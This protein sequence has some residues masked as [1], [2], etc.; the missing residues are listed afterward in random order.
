MGEGLPE[1]RERE[2]RERGILFSDEMV[3]RILSG[4]K[5]R[6]R[7]YAR[8][9]EDPNAPE[10]IA[11]RLANGLYS[12]PPDGC[13]VWTRTARASGHGT[14]TVHGRAVSVHRL[15]YELGVGPIPPGKWVLHRCDNPRCINPS[16]LEIGDQAKNMADCAARGRSARGARNGRARLSAPKVANIRALLATGLSQAGVAAQFG[17][18]QATVGRIARMESWR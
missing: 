6:K 7:L 10:H 2:R 8:R 13:W 3:R 1:R 14:M 18:T 17:V 9:G 15:A 11:Q 12:A 4:E 5:T 16:H